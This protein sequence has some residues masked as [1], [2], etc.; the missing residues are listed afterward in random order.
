VG[1]IDVAPALTAEELASVTWAHTTRTFAALG[2]RFAVRSS[3]AGIG[4]YID[5]MYAGCAVTGRDPAALYS[6]LNG[7][8]GDAPHALYLGHDRMVQ[9]ARPAPILNHLTWHVNQ[10]VIAERGDRVLLHAAAAAL[11]ERGVLLPAAMEAGKT[12]LVA[13]LIRSGFRYLTD[14]AAA[15]DPDTLLVHPYAK[16]LSID[17]GSWEVL[18]DLRPR[19]DPSTAAYLEGQWQV[20]AGAIRDDAISE[21]VGVEVVI[22]P[23]YELGASTT[24]T[25]L[26]R[27]TALVRAL[28]QT[29]RFHERGARDLDVLR[30]V[31]ER[32]RC[33]QLV[34][35]DLA[36]ASAEVTRLVQGDDEHAIGT[37]VGA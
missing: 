16:P 23:R 8:P 25:R 26:R 29:F 5:A 24:V 3:G 4:R 21:P 34:S 15:I 27:S 36:Q 31:V 13:G 33:Y 30:R 11:G 37:E 9:S 1:P 35:G 32:A 28:E 14:E 17:P 20:P 2:H 18:A 7:L 19:L 22:L 6:V 10:R 12:T